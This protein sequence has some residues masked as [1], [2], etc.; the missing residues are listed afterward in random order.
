MWGNMKLI[1]LSKEL[2]PQFFNE[3]QGDDYRFKIGSVLVFLDDNNQKTELKIVRL[4][5]SKRICK[6]QPVKLYTEDEINAMER[7]DAEDI[8]KNG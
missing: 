8:I 3:K 2:T 7:T 4:N 5:R 1:D 6:V